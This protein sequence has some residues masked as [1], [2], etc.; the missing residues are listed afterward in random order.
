MLLPGPS[1]KSNWSALF[2][3]VVCF[4]SAGIAAQGDTIYVSNGGNGTIDKIDANGNVSVFASGLSEPSGLA[5]DAHGDLYVSDFGDGK[6]LEFAPNGGS[7]TFM[8]VPPHIV[9]DIA[10]DSA[11]D[12]YFCGSGEV[13]ELN[14]NGQWFTVASGLGLPADMAFDGRGNLYVSD[15]TK[16]TVDMINSSGTLSVFASGLDWPLGLAFDP[17]GNLYVANSGTDTISRIT[18]DGSNSVFAYTYAYA[19]GLGFDSNGKLYATDSMG[20]L[21]VINSSGYGSIFASGLSSPAYMVV[22]PIPEPATNILL[23][24]GLMGLFALRRSRQR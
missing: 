22:Q 8:T 4:L 3:T 12:F 13:D 14:T 17:S 15:N 18:P 10:F 11:G 20:H 1:T 9:T 19:G 5:F 7:S 24:T 23:L 21:E 6:I 16:N 2:V